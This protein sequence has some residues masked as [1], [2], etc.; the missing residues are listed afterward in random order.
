MSNTTITIGSRYNANPVRE[1]LLYI[2]SK[3]MLIPGS[4]MESFSI[5]LPWSYQL[6]AVELCH[7]T[8]PNVFFNINASNQV[9]PTNLGNFT[10]SHWYI[11]I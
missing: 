3:Q 5:Q 1:K 8:I 10:L 7:V 9:V 2:S 6:E 4:L 11:Y